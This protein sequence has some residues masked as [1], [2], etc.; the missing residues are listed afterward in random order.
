MRSYHV[1][2]KKILDVLGWEPKRSIEDAVRDLCVA[3]REGKL[4]SDAA[5]RRA[6]AFKG[7]DAARLRYL[8]EAE[9]RRLLN[10]CPPAFR[11]L[12]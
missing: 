4:P 11:R 7:A 6:K 10:A 5:W 12:P 8:S 3:F 1:S 2:S 9:A